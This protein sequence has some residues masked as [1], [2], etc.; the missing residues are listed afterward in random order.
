[1]A[2]AIF[3]SRLKPPFLK[4]TALFTDALCHRGDAAALPDTPAAEAVAAP[5]PQAAAQ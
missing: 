2:K 3:V 1:M 4:N 5:E